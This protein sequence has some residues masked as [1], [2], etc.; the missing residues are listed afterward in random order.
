MVKFNQSGGKR[1]LDG[2]DGIAHVA[3]K[4][5]LGKRA[6]I[7]VAVMAGLSGALALIGP[8]SDKKFDAPRTHYSAKYNQYHTSGGSPEGS[9]G[10]SS[11]SDGYNPAGG[12]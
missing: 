4:M 7:Y 9:Y 12:N 3:S 10:G 11:S 6:V 1:T 5:S 8:C 2:M